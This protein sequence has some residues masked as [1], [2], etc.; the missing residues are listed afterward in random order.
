M[1]IPVITLYQPWATFIML[2]WKTIETR[3]HDRL[4]SLLGKTIG[5]HAGKHYDKNHGAEQWMSAEQKE[6]FKE[7]EFQTGAFLGTVKV[8]SFSVLDKCNSESALIDCEQTERHGLFLSN[9]K[10]SIPVIV[11]GSM[12]IWYYDTET[13][14]AVAKPK[15]NIKSQWYGTAKTLPGLFN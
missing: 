10:P 2:G 9:P 11:N 12:G 13:K 5:I 1:I 8:D 3:T 15:I 14:S 6:R 7:I 4:K